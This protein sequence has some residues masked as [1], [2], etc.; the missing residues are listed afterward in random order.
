LTRGSSDARAAQAPRPN[1]VVIETD[2][3]TAEQLRVMRKTLRLLGD[4]GTTFDRSFVTLSLCCP[5]RATLLT[6][7]YAHNSGVLTNSLPYGGYQKL[8]HRNTLAVWLQGAGYWTAHVGK[9][10]NGYGKK[11]A[12]RQIPPGWSE[13]HAGVNLPY[14]GFTT[15]DDGVLHQ[16]G[17]NPSDYQTDVFTRKAVGVIDRRAPQAKPFFLWLA[18]HAPHAGGPREPDDPQGIATVNTGPKYRNHFASEALPRP[19]SFNERDVSDKPVGIRNRPL[20]TASVVAGVREAY[21]QQ[22]ESLLAVDD[23]VQAVVNALRAT[24]ELDNTLI[25]FT[26]DNGFFR[27]EHRVPSGKVLLYEPSIRVPL[28]MRGPAV[29]RGKHLEQ[30][31][32]NIDLAPTILAAALAKAGRR[33]D[34]RSLWPLLRHPGRQWGRDLLIE[35]GPGGGKGGSVSAGRAGDAGEGPGDS[36]NQGRR[37]AGPPDRRFAAIRTPRFLYAE[38][39]NGERELYDLWKDPDELRSLH[40]SRAYA[41]IRRELARRLAKL[42]TCRGATCSAGPRV[43]LKVRRRSHAA[44]AARCTRSAVRVRVAGRDARWVSSARFFL[45]GKLRRA[46]SKA[47][48][49]V[50]IPKRSLL[51]HPSIRARVSFLDGRMVDRTRA[52]PRA[53][54]R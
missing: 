25:V 37:A 19:P 12:R 53:C 47:P 40:G 11:G 24:G 48:F 10:L 39:V 30:M 29:P 17:S 32:A 28:L 35:R 41:P 13:W 18:Y 51:R 27:G 1:I 44:A 4:E 14:F 38:Y 34:G 54:R 50:T 23:G 45:N 8:D 15:N 16:Y 21:Q 26:D 36:G 31:V 43:K 9:Y 6:G 33:M 5:S 20:M 42:R 3:Q 22:L 7:Q 49:Q 52:L 46:D 2:D